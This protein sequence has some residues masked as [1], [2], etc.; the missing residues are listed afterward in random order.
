M[1]TIPP[2]SRKIALIS[3]LLLL[4]GCAK[5]APSAPVADAAPA[6]SAPASGEARAAASSSPPATPAQRGADLAADDETSSAPSGEARRVHLARIEDDELLA[7]SA[8]ATA[9]RAHF[10]GHDAGAKLAALA[11]D[12]QIV[13][14]GGGRRGYLLTRDR[15]AEKGAKH[16]ERDDV[17]PQIVVV[18]SKGAILWTKENP[19]AGVVAKI[20]QLAIA[21]GPMGGIALVLVSAPTKAVATRM[22]DG[23]GGI[24][25]D[26]HV[27]DTEACDA[28]SVLYAARRGWLVVAT[29]MG[30]GR[31]QLL[32]ERGTLA[33]GKSGMPVGMA[34]TIATSSALAQDTETTFMLVQLA[35]GPDHA[36]LHAFAI[37]Y[38]R[39]GTPLWDAPVDLGSVA[40]TVKNGDR[41]VATR[42]REGVVRVVLPGAPKSARPVD[43][44]ADGD[45][46]RAS[47]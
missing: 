8:T 21:P 28:L 3:S 29:R 40:R 11:L 37:R 43:I 36:S 10:A 26:F 27:L 33:W 46:L 32:D 5:A 41:A 47:P 9:V 1:R 22:W 7:T 2:V 16:D 12:A 17:P 23:E 39:K 44:T 24:F 34:S 30:I 14:L 13:K 18:D 4:S 38:D 42:L 20:T 31:A 6:P 35:P 19:I 25:A 45:V 15:S